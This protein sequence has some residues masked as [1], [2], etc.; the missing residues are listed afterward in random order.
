L[1]LLRHPQVCCAA[2]STAAC[3]C[4][5]VKAIHHILATH[6]TSA[7][8]KQELLACN[9]L[10]TLTQ[11]MGRSTLPLECRAAAAGCLHHYL[12]PQAA[13]GLGGVGGA[14]VQLASLAAGGH[15]PLNCILHL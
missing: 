4:S 2:G 13:A 9:G 15:V 5:A 12:A 6:G 10:H 7:A 14:A 3:R 11:I 1:H 8:V